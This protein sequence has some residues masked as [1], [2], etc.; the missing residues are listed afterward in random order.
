MQ[1][2]SDDDEEPQ[3]KEQPPAQPIV[4]E[5]SDDEFDTYKIDIK[6]LDKEF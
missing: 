3:V 1:Q 4:D 6:I 5:K 2:L